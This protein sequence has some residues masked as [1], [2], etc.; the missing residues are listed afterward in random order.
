[1]YKF[2]K[3]TKS[4]TW[5]SHP[6]VEVRNY[7]PDKEL[8]NFINI[9]QMNQNGNTQTRVQWYLPAKTEKSLVISFYYK[10]IVIVISL[11]MKLIVV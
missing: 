7:K 5:R 10:I 11:I 3:I 6:L 1:M 2:L 9:Q 8:Q 4:T